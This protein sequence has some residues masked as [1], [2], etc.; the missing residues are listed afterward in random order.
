MAEAAA[1][2]RARKLVA[3]PTE[4]VYGLG[5]NA[6][7]ARA[8]ER[9]FRAKGRS[10]GNPLIVHVAD[11]AA[12]AALAA[13]WPLEADRLASRFWPGP[14]S[15]VV[16][17][18]PRIP[19]VVTA[20]G[21]TVAV[22]VPAHPVA[23]AL[24]QAAGVPIAAPS[25]N[26]S[27]TVSPTTAR[28][29]LDSLADAVDLV[30]DAG[31]TPAGIESTIVDLTESVPRVLRPGP[32]APGDLANCLEREVL[33]ATGAA[34]TSGPARSPGQQERHYAP[35]A[36]LMLASPQEAAAVAAKLLSAGRRI[37]GL[38]RR[39]DEG[40]LAPI[41]DALRVVLPDDAASFAAGLYAALHQLDALGVETILAIE[42]PETEAWLAIRDRLRRGSS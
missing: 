11:A 1:E 36:R 24:C 37:G 18:T 19:D 3:F 10:A 25:A 30:I 21:P 29:V 9:I 6:F 5:A 26:R 28:H 31:P 13:D 14:L 38:C 12:A 34:E 40:G 41:D 32:I 7:D 39:A 42:P 23:L 17:R 22:R 8:V 4:T 35:R 20:G 16:R 27:L 33:V 15:I 2:L